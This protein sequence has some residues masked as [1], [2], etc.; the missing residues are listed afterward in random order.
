MKTTFSKLAVVSFAALLMASCSDSNN[1]SPTQAMNT[2]IVGSE[3]VSQ[4]DAQALA[5]RVANFKAKTTTK[6]RTIDENNSSYFEGIISMPEEPKVPEEAIELKNG[7]NSSASNASYVL[8]SGQ[9]LDTSSAGISMGS[10]PTI[11]IENGATLKCNW[12]YQGATIYV[13]KGGTLVDTNSSPVKSMN[14]YN[15]GTFTT[16]EDELLVGAN[17]G[18]FYSATD[19]DLSGKKFNVQSKCY[20]G[21]NLTV[22]ELPNNSGM[23]MNV[24]G[25]LTVES[26]GELRLSGG[27]LNVDGI[28]SC[29]G[30]L[31][32]NSG[33]KVYSGCA[34]KVA[35]TLNLSGN[36]YYTPDN[37]ELHAA[38]VKAENI[39]QA[40]GSKIILKS[41]SFIDCN[42]TYFN[43]N[44]D[45]AG[46]KLE[47]DNA[48]AVVKASKIKWNTGSPVYETN[49]DGSTNYNKVKGYEIAT[50]E[51][52]GT[53]SKLLFDGQF[54]ANNVADP[55]NPLFLDQDCYTQ[56]DKNNIKDIIIKKTECNGNKGYNDPD[57]P[58][59]PDDPKPTE[60]AIEVISKIDYD[61]T[62]DISA[63]CIQPYNGK[64]YMSYHTRGRGHGACIE[65]FDPVNANKE[66]K[67]DQYFY[68]KAGTL[69][70]NH[71]MVDQ[72][73]KRVYVVG[74]SS[75]KGAMM[76][77]V[78][79]KDD[80]LLNSEPK[81][82]T[83]DGGETKTY[84]PLNIL[85]LQKATAEFSNWDENCIDK[86]DAANRYVVMTTK[87]YT[88]YDV[89][90]LNKLETI[91]KS[92][93]AKHVDI[94]EGK[95]ATLY[96]EKEAT[97]TD[98]AINA[99]VE[100][101]SKGG[102]LNSPTSTFEVG[103]I[104]PNN[105][106][107]V[108]ALKDNKIYVCRGVAGIYCYDMNGTE[109]WHYQM[110]NPINEK[111]EYKA[112]ANGCYVGNDG[113]VYVA[114]GSYGL[115][116]LDTNKIEN[117]APKVVA[118]R[119]IGHSANYVTVYNDYIYVANGRSRLG[120]FHL[121][122]YNK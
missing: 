39:E 120:V 62:H 102:D 121:I 40:A 119:N 16:T 64:M 108:L 59:T 45:A 53:N 38:Y 8:K 18:K 72:Q 86:D 94:E 25:N 101:F 43:H 104:Q 87:G 99:R 80:G 106:K 61:H 75:K 20:I 69:D 57:T 22:G 98:E 82:I 84:Q 60:P 63:T 11:Y 117:G 105:G 71:L 32:L 24:K 113:L 65:V 97:T 44:D 58:T 50:F 41:Q 70:F 109:Q 6:S 52:P 46:S 54:Y 4:T 2:S 36:P 33:C 122:N 110:P 48:V 91:D 83:V 77:Y 79:L 85:P 13:L 67:L 112:Y 49:E 114:Y 95:I 81:N 27:L 19:V 68:D 56:Y 107:N 76:A 31:Q 29:K 9:T 100:V 115:V 17:G 37:S 23:C 26:T 111:G 10:N 3:V 116:I 73:Q 35:G 30:D 93:K 14:I 47:G 92:G 7:L 51:T 103:T 28:F 15:Y 88:T 118:Q 55:I 96:L 12:Y 34:V 1:D 42:D 74:S 5:S 78:D 66:V 21:G 90:T 89:N